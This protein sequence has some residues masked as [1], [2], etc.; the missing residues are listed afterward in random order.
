MMLGAGEMVATASPNSVYGSGFAGP[1]ST[2]AT[3]VTVGGGVGPFTYAWARTSG[4]GGAANVPNGS[5][6]QFTA[7]MGSGQT[8]ASV[9]ACV[10]TDTAT[11]K[12]VQVSVDAA[13]DAF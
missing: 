11:G 5:T 6:T 3:T 10:V 8:L 7:S 9:F 2:E 12:S 1:I 4:A 13:W